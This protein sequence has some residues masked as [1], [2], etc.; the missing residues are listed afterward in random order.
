MKLPNKRYTSMLKYY[1]LAIIV[2]M[3]SGIFGMIFMGFNE[4]VDF[5]PATQITVSSTIEDLS[6]NKNKLNTY[7]KEQ[8]LSIQREYV[9]E[10]GLDR[11]IIAVV[12]GDI[13]YINVTYI[14]EDELN[15]SE[16][17]IENISNTVYKD[18]TWKIIVI[19]AST[20][21]LTILYFGIQK[22]WIN[23]FVSAFG[24]LI[25][26][27]LSLSIILLTRIDVTVNGM[28]LVAVSSLITSVLS[29]LINEK[30]RR[31]HELKDLKEHT[32]V[33]VANEVISTDLFGV[34]LVFGSLLLINIILN[35]VYINV[36]MVNRF[37]LQA[38]VVIIVTYLISLFVSP[39]IFAELTNA[40]NDRQ[41]QKLSKNV[42]N[43]KS[44]NASSLDTSKAKRKK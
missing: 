4:S 6:L 17:N 8:N 1:M 44:S 9:E 10:D 11:T 34:S 30:I 5:V 40:Y 15:F 14:L 42:T 26:S 36:F 22:S 16:V 33:D 29:G 28:V 27:I 35:L 41:K 23:G 2:I 21:I 31:K 19:V 43:V 24:G 18:F 7:L 38:I 37:M 39:S 20:L 32:Y 13:D 3:I 25:T 12:K